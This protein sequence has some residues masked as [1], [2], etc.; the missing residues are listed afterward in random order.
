MTAS[1]TMRRFRRAAVIPAAVLASFTLVACGSSSDDSDSGSSGGFQL[2]L[3][4]CED[5]D[6]VSKKITDTIAVGYSAPLSGPIAGA[7]EL[8]TA[9]YNARIEAANAE[10]GIDGVKIEVT[11]KDD[12]FAPD[13][14]KANATEF[15]QKDKVDLVTTFGAGQVAAIADDQNAACVPMLY[16][17][18]S[19]V[20]FND[21]EAY[22][23]TLQFLPSADVETKFII[24][25][26]KS[27]VDD[28]KLGIAENATASG[29]AMAESFKKSAEA[30]DLKIEA[31]TEDTDPSAAATKLKAAGVNVLYHGGVTG[32]C[33]VLDTAMARVDFKPELVVKASNCANAAEYITAGK[34]ADGAVVPKYLKEPADPEMTDDEGIKQ[35][36]SQV[37]D[38]ADPNNTITVSGWLAGDLLVNTLK[39]AAASED[40]LTRESIMKAARDQDY[41]SPVLLDGVTWK[42]TAERS[43][44]VSGFGPF[45][46]SHADKRFVSAG[47][48]LDVD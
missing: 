37:S 1:T 25:F 6:A 8:A 41:A 38:V 7:A 2:N 39:Q 26:M 4:D 36:L 48:V 20:R 43:G 3:D 18:S 29:A 30:A 10:G 44:G 14:A 13:K 47:D 11:Y 46:W 35:Y 34:A 19:D 28:I 33:G 17:S 24:D 12:A 23:W 45:A 27:K 22:P 5:P 16:P 31:E 42:S 32:T 40:G 15:L 9:G 21:I